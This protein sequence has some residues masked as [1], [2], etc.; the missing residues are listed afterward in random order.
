MMQ[1]L[2][3]GWYLPTSGDT[4]CYGDPACQVPPSLEL[5]DRVIGAAE[6]AG[7]EYFLIPVTAACWE[8]WITSAMM[9]ARH[10]RIRALVA[11]KPGFIKPTMMAKMVATFDQLSGGRVCVNLIAGQSEAEL[12]ADGILTAKED[13]YAQMEED[14]RVMKALWTATGPIDFDGRFTTLTNAQVQPKPLQAGGPRFY[15]GGGSRDAWEVSARHSDVHLFWGDTPER[16]AA[17]MVEIRG[18]AAR[19]G[20]AE[21]LQFGMRL[22]IICRETEDAAWAAA[23]ELMRGATDEQT[24]RLQQNIA[25]SAANQRVQE[26]RATHGDLIAPHMWTGVSKVRAGAGIVVVGNP[27]QCAETL[28]RFIDLGCTSFCLSGYTHDA[29]A[30]RFGRLVRPLLVQRNGHRM[31]AA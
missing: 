26:L 5:F 15:L 7:F 10:S 9:L 18:M 12:R 22:Q 31:A 29:E 6:A 25:N 21:T 23:H 24:S 27:V 8:A 14:V 13:R 2:E 19:H 16:I 4:T 20:R 28:Q 17:N 1:Q 3:F 30:E 11:A